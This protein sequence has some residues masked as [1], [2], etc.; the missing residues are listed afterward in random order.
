MEAYPEFSI[1]VA[2]A[3]MTGNVAGV[4]NRKRLQKGAKNDIERIH[5]FQDGLFE[6]K[7]KKLAYENAAK[8]MEFKPY[9]QYYNNGAFIRTLIPLFKKSIYKHDVMIQKLQKQPATL[10]RCASVE[11][12]IHLLE[13]VYNFRSKS[14]VSLQYGK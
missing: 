3:I 12:Y 8:I 7:N 5:F 2:E 1:G 6:V 4:N 14:P 10:V 11:Q 9:F 13:M